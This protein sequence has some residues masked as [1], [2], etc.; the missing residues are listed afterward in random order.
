[1]NEEIQ[2][3]ICECKMKKHE[4]NMPQ[5]LLEDSNDRVCRDCNDYVT[6]FRII[7][8]GVDEETLR[9]MGNVIADIMCMAAG[10]KRSRE[11][12]LKKMEEE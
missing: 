11:F 2:C 1:M 3:K 4:S 8:R 12:W 6:A 10:F 9:H 5:P 7:F